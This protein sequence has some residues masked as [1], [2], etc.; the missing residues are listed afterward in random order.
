[1]K[2]KAGDRIRIKGGPYAG[3]E[4]DAVERAVDEGQ[5]V[6]FVDEEGRK[7]STH[8][9]NAELVTGEAPTL[10]DHTDE[11]GD[12]LVVRDAGGDSFIL[13]GRTCGRPQTEVV[14]LTREEMHAVMT[15][16]SCDG[17]VSLAGDRITFV[18][19]G[20][21]VRLG[22]R[23]IEELTALC[24][25]SK[26]ADG[27][28]LESTDDDGYTL[29]VFEAPGGF[30]LVAGELDLHR[31][32]GMRADVE[33]ASMYVSQEDLRIVMDGGPGV[34]GVSWAD[35]N[36][37]I[38]DHV[39]VCLSPGEEEALLALRVPEEAPDLKP[40]G[41]KR[42]WWLMPFD[43]LALAFEH[44]EDHP[45]DSPPSLTTALAHYQREPSQETARG[46]ALAGLSDMTEMF[47]LTAALDLVVQVFE[48]GAKK[49]T[50]DNWRGAA[51][52]RE[53]FRREYLSAICRHSF[54]LDGPIDL[55]HTLPDGTLIKGSGLP[56]AAHAVCGALMILWHEMRT[57]S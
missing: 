5:F 20:D 39:G 36:L 35:C 43:A 44:A 11:Y 47:E 34:E 56:H 54:P 31:A 12:R 45:G 33:S 25:P 38:L 9:G 42:Q 57:F 46:L 3:G 24:A 10:L 22:D 2:I 1:M 21:S 29:R 26:E 52:D 6:S 50:E 15:S 7:V 28:L 49:Y 55:D 17:A 40:R 8:P 51:T 4:Y 19:N 18:G 27:M 32:G 16:G 30:R 41:V 48:H 23:V 14:Y 13:E 53:A 37:Y